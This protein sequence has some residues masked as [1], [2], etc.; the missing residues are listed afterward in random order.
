MFI[1]LND[2]LFFELFWM[3]MF[4]SLFLFIFYFFLIKEP[5]NK[6]LNLNTD[7]K[8]KKNVKFFKNMFIDDYY[9]LIKFIY[10]FAIYIYILLFINNSYIFM[11]S[12][13]SYFTNFHIY[14][15]I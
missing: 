6:I 2:I 9:N 1:F 13:N 3:P 8:I 11:Y 5:V 12:S 14:N 4:I 10:K 7:I 15:Y